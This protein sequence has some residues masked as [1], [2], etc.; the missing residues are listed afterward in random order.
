LVTK[1]VP[2]NDI[3]IFYRE[4][5]FAFKSVFVFL[6]LLR[7]LREKEKRKAARTAKQM[8]VFKIVSVY[9]R[10]RS[11][12]AG[13]IELIYYRISDCRELTNQFEKNWSNRSR[14]NNSGVPH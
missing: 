11:L 3:S 12:R 6:R 1:N 13:V 5:T 7:S 14:D 4:D 2:R 8:K 9:L 10:S